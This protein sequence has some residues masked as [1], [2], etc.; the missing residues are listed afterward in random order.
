VGKSPPPDST[1]SSPRA[2]GKGRRGEGTIVFF[3]HEWQWRRT[4]MGPENNGNVFVHRHDR[5]DAGGKKKG[6]K[7]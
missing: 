5:G 3:T 4:K 1:L 6:K 7:K 2:S